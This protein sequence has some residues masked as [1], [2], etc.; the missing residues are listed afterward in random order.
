MAT[1]KPDRDDLSSGARTT[2]EDTLPQR[3]VPLPAAGTKPA[4]APIQKDGERDLPLV[5]A[6]V[7]ARATG[8][9]RDQVAGFLAWA[10]VQAAPKMTI[11]Q[12]EV[13][14]TRCMNRPV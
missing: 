11:P 2:I 5:T 4:E 9:K 1:K 10:R 8:R 14:W 13:E 3:A 7:F 6:E 12:W